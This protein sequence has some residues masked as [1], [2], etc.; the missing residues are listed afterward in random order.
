LVGGAS[1]GVKRRAQE[2][3]SEGLDAAKNAAGEAFAQ[4]S[5]QAE[6][7]G[8]TPGGIAK[9]AQDLGQRVQRV[10]ES[11]VTTAFDPSQEDHQPRNRGDT[12]HG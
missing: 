8:L 9:A 4:A 5:Q 1:S 10:T 7:E 2:A 6:A 3:A 11:A 12:D